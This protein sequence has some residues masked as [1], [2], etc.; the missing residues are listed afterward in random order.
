MARFYSAFKFYME[1]T[2]RKSQWQ[3]RLGVPGYE[4]SAS[5]FHKVVVQQVREFQDC[6]YSNGVAMAMTHCI[7]DASRTGEHHFVASM[8]YVHMRQ[9]MELTRTQMHRD[10]MVARLEDFGDPEKV[11]RVVNDV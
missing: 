1:Q 10:I 2:D 3:Q 9:W 6:L 8:Y 11:P 7:V 5:Y 4:P